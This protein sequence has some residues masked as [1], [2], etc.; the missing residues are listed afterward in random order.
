MS[1]KYYY[2]EHGKLKQLWK[3]R[4]VIVL[5]FYLISGSCNCVKPQWA[6]YN[7]P[8]QNLGQIDHSFHDHV[9]DDVRCKPPR[10]LRAS[11]SLEVVT[12]WI[13]RLILCRYQFDQ[14]PSPQA[15]WDFCTKMCAQPKAFAK[16]KMS[17]ARPINNDVPGAR[18]LYQLAFKLENS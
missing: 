5:G 11:E 7:R 17:R 14:L 10:Y 2:K 4:T 15:P 16:Q 8:H 6:Y 1:G 13:L 3:E 18:L 9:F 12:G